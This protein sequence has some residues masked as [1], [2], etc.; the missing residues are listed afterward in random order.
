V[1]GSLPSEYVTYT[2]VTARYKRVKTRF[3]TYKTVTARYK[4][5]KARFGTYKTVTASYE[6]VKA[7]FGTYKAV[8]AR[9]WPWRSGKSPQNLSRC[10]LFA[11]E[12]VTRIWSDIIT[13]SIYSRGS[14]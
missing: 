6:R 4:T 12:R 8:R 13:Q 7:R 2:T 1:L 10:S 3:D 11:R 5:V 14:N 9:F